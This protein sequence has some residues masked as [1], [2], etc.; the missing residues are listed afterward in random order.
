VRP[1]FVD[2]LLSTPFETAVR[3]AGTVTEM[4]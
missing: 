4:S 2:W 1:F 3:P